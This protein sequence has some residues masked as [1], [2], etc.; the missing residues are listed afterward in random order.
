M[1]NAKEQEVE[2]NTAGQLQKQRITTLEKEKNEY[3]N[4]IDQLK[5]N[6][7]GLKLDRDCMYTE[8]SKNLYSPDMFLSDEVHRN[9]YIYIYIVQRKF[10]ES[11]WEISY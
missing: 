8:I 1:L 4:K 6:F 10:L 5:K 7:L 2:A 9:I 11:H 3:L